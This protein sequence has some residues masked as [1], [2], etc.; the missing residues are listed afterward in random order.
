MLVLLLYYSLPLARVEP[1]LLNMYIEYSLSHLCD[2]NSKLR[3][4]LFRIVDKY[5]PIIILFFVRLNFSMV[6]AGVIFLLA[7]FSIH[8]SRFFL[9]LFYSCFCC[10]CQYI[11]YRDAIDWN[12]SKHTKRNTKEKMQ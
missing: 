10:F 6:C 7:S 1:S 11:W 4:Y 5:F 2:E 9:L 12:F 8:K 3:G